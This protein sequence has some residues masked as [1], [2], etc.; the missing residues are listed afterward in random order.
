MIHKTLE[1]YHRDP[2]QDILELFDRAWIESNITN[3][4]YYRDGRKMLR[5]YLL[6]DAYHMYPVAKG[7]DGEPLLETYF[8]IP[9]DEQGDVLVSGVIDRIDKISEDTVRIIDYKTGFVPKTRDELETDEQLTIYNLAV[10]HLYPEWQNVRLALLF[11]RYGLLE[12]TRTAEEIEAVR[13]LFINTYYQI[14][15]NDDPQPQLNSY[16]GYCP[17]KHKCPEYQ[18]LTKEELVLMGDFPDAPNLLLDELESVKVKTKILNDRRKEI[19][20]TLSSLIEGAD[21]GYVVAGNKKIKLAPKRRSFYP[22]KEVRKILGEE[23]VAQIA[24]LSK[25]DV[26]KLVKNDEDTKKQL[27]ETLVTYYTKPSLKVEDI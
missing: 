5:E 8:R 14:K 1:D 11:T 16:C 20:S 21:G 23:T 3:L 27:E 15:L 6:T 18:K 25:R 10:N 17:I 7:R 4:D 12:T 9:L 24:N 22:Y 26:E 19:E 2:S 13:H